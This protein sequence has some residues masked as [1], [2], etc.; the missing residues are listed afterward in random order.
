VP[1]DEERITTLEKDLALLRERVTGMEARAESTSTREDLE[2]AKSDVLRIVLGS[3]GV[4]TGII[5]GVVAI[6][7]TVIVDILK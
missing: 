3:G 2:K 7:V 6:A 4:I 5:I 1:S